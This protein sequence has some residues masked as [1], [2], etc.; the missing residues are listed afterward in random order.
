MLG[1]VEAGRAEEGSEV[2]EECG[3]GLTWCW[4]RRRTVAGVFQ[5]DADFGVAAV[6]G[7]D[8]AELGD[9]GG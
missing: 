6:V 9:Q 5:A 2:A 3:A 7:E 4:S 8:F 1:G